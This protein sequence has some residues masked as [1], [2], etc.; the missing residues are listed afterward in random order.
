MIRA[1]KEPEAFGK[2]TGSRG[3]G[4]LESESAGTIGMDPGCFVNWIENK[5]MLRISAFRFSKDR[6]SSSFDPLKASHFVFD[7]RVNPQG[8]EPWTLSLKGRCSTS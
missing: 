2:A 7:H 6:A 8:L 5:E 1:K 3:K 4:D